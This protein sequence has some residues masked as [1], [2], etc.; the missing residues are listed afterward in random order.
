[1]EVNALIHV[2]GAKEPEHLAKTFSILSLQV[3]YVW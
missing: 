3:L 2:I 1:M